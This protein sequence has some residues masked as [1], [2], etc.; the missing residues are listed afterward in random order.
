[1]AQLRRSRQHGEQ[2]ARRI[3]PLERIYLALGDRLG[4]SLER[5][6]SDR[7]SLAPRWTP[8]RTA[9]LGIAI[10][11]YL[12]ALGCIA[13]GALVIV[14]GWPNVGLV[15]LGVTCLGVGGVCCPKPYGRSR[16][17]G[18]VTPASLPQL[19]A[20]I[21][22]VADALNVRRP[23]VVLFDLRYNASWGH[24]GWR[25]RRILR[26]GVPLLASLDVDQTVALLA[27]E[28]AHE[29][30][31][32]SRRS[33]VVGSSLA[34]LSSALALLGRERTRGY[35]GLALLSLLFTNAVLWLCRQPF[36]GLLVLQAHLLYRDSQ[37]AEYLADDLAASV[38]GTDAVIA[39]HDTTLAVTAVEVAIRRV[40]LSNDRA[41]SSLLDDIHTAARTADPAA[42]TERRR[43][44]RA[45]RRR[46]DGTHPTTA[47]RIVVLQRRPARSASVV[48]DQN[49]K[50]ALRDELRSVMQKHTHALID[51]D[52]ARLYYG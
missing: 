8:A 9:A 30:N 20:A 46:L 11:A 16:V 13:V 42:R 49:A 12:G 4:E 31:G 19:H 39:L 52:R 25:R 33:R 43:L 36:R 34:S 40:S 1:M 2:S 28:L 45:E 32:D 51:H 15:I 6:M 24:D 47:S 18:G 38:A 26:L 27:H 29:R 10:G 44:A 7:D 17:R 22:Q 3:G 50:S 5:E 21:C 48:L 37:R 35:R 41:G 14:S 23:D